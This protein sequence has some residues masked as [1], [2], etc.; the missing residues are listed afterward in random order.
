MGGAVDCCGVDNILDVMEGGC[1]GGSR[2]AHFP[3]IWC[4]IIERAVLG[5]ASWVQE[6]EEAVG[7]TEGCLVCVVYVGCTKVVLEVAYWLPP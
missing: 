4:T 5:L 6:L 2:A 7:V 3:C 1:G